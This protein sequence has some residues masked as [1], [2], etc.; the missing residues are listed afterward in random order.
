MCGA[1]NDFIVIDSIPKMDYK[2]L[3]FQIC[4][5]TDGIGADGL[6]VLE[7]SQKGDYRMRIINSDG[8]EAEM[9][10]NGARCMAVYIKKT[11]KPKKGLLTLETLAGLIQ[12]EANGEKACVRL[13]DPKDYQADIPLKINGKEIHIQYIDTGVPHAIVYVDGLNHINV[14]KIGKIIRYHRRFLPRGTNVDF[15][16]QIKQNFIGLRTY[17]RGVEDE[18]KACGTGSVAAAIVSYCKANPLI[19]EVKQ[20][21]MKVLTRSQEI[22]DVTFDIH[23][24]Q[25]TNVWLKGSAKFIAQG[26]FF[27][28]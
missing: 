21:H 2:R 5:R 8:S 6:L 28:R 12:A 23:Q 9:C 13:S 3:C 17:E 25:M 11:R 20:A 15:V 7:P 10:G 27:L 22:L 14:S 16:E 18:T 19:Q 4:H 24:N 1:G 26:E